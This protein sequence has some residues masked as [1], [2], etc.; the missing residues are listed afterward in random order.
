MHSPRATRGVRV[1]NLNKPD[2]AAVLSL[3][4][5]LLETSMDDVELG[6]VRDFFLR[7]KEFL[8]A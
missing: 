6:I 1:L 2:R 7:N 3:E 4:G 5:E 8:A